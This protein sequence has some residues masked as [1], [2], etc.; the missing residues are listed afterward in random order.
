MRLMQTV[1]TRASSRRAEARGGS[2]DQERQAEWLTR[3]EQAEALL[4]EKSTQPQADRTQRGRGRSRGRGQKAGGFTG[5]QITQAGQR[6]AG[7]AT[8]NQKGQG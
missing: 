6:Q 7:L 2:Q 1:L 3:N 5:R 8:R 4:K